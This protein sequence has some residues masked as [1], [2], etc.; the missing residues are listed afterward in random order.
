MKKILFFV[1]ILAAFLGGIWTGRHLSQPGYSGSEVP[2]LDRDYYDKA[3]SL[4][5]G[6]DRT[7]H[8]LMFE[9]FYYPQHPESKTNILLQELVNAHRRGVNVK[10]CVEGGE[11]YL[12][13]DF[14]R[15]QLRGYRYLKE[16]GVEI[17]V[18]PKG[19]TSH[20]KLLIVDGRTV[21]LG[22]TNWSYHALEKN[23]ETNV[24]VESP[25]LASSFEKY[26]NRI[27]KSSSTLNLEASLRS[28]SPISKIL[29]EPGSWDGKRVR[30]SGEVAEL[31]K[32]R[33]R[34]GNLYST[35]YLSDGE[36]NR[37]KVF[38]WGHPDVDNG[39]QV[40]VE[41]VFKKEKRIGKLSFYNELEAET[42]TR[43]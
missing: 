16:N 24:L 32:R 4:I 27:W 3:L 40:E 15:K 34:S 6:A 7:I 22:S 35:F 5:R 29:R 25:S 33:S 2:V 28:H 11:D 23:S 10:V 30:I 21:L 41:G 36:G 1:L 17:R 31:K 39:E 38:K 43:R 26:F 37:I 12:G 42:I 20:A 13:E 8:I 9:L 19:V 18:D 14:L